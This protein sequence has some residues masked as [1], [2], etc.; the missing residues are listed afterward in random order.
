MLR[1]F[2]PYPRL[3]IRVL[4]L[5]AFIGL[6]RYLSNSSSSST[7]MSPP[8]DASEVA[9]ALLSEHGLYLQ[10][11][12]VLQSLWAGYG[13]ICRITATPNSPQ[14]ST[15]TSRTASSA[16]TPQQFQSYILKL[17]APPPT[18]SNNE[19]H[20]R[21]ILSYQVEQYFYT[22][23]APQMPPSIPVAKA[24]SSTH[25]SRSGGSLKM[26]MLLTDL[27]QIYPIAGEKRSE[28][29][30]IQV[31]AALDWLSSFH[32]FWQPRVK[33]FDHTSLVRPPLE[34]ETHRKQQERLNSRNDNTTTVWLNGGYTYLATRQSEYT[35]LLS[36]HDSEWHEPLTDWIQDTSSISHYVAAVLSPP[37]TATSH[38]PTTPYM[39]LL[40]G[41][42]KSENLFTTS[43]MKTAVMYDFQYVGLGLGVCDLAK[44][45][46][47]SVPLSLLVPSDLL[48]ASLPRKLSMQEGEVALLRRY[49]T[50]VKEKS[51]QAYDWDIF[52]RHWETALV[53]WCRFQ[54]SW[55]FW[56]N[57]EWL[58]ARV[59]WVLADE[60]WRDG[61]LGMGEVEGEKGCVTLLLH[62]LH[63]I[64]ALAIATTSIHPI[65]TT[66][67]KIEFSNL[68]LIQF[69]AVPSAPPTIPLHSTFSPP[70]PRSVREYSN[71]LFSQ[72][73]C[74]MRY[75]QYAHYTKF[76][77]SPGPK[78]CCGTYDAS[79]INSF[80]VKFLI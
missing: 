44:L 52:V 27:K 49:W 22:H 73:S 26:A 18:S 50:N 42:V 28:L 24:L 62:R 60:G 70:F 2:G 71:A 41:D 43:D 63:R 12:Q 35:S 72:F 78:C 64:H 47:C 3:I 9:S 80:S 21:K 59:R 23:L 79:S 66:A 61:V 51:G 15:S 58:G 32:G 16:S 11:I 19:G 77:I 30:S 13:K 14:S 55:G 33:D 31:D 36:S 29:T 57:E 53:D 56:G 10:S 6:A 39:T 68:P 17:I 5:A 25:E 69:I 74:L 67:T 20:I 1:S 38:T 54:A 65:E 76:P 4:L 46:T 37:K 7:T 48:S 75:L 8:P 40:H 34:E 45:F